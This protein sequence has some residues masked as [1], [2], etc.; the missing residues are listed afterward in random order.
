MRIKQKSFLIA[1]LLFGAVVL[2]S[3]CKKKLEDPK[4]LAVATGPSV[5]I[6]DLRNMYA[7]LNIKFTSNSILHAVVTMDESS[8]NAYKMVYIRDNSGPAVTNGYGAISL[9][10]LNSSNGYLAVGDSIAINLNG[11][12]LD[13]SNGGS[14]QL[15]SIR[16][17]SNIVKIKTGLNPAPL[18]ITLPQLNTVVGTQ[19]VYDGQ[20][21]QLNNVE[22]VQPNVGLPY[23]TGQNP[24]AA[25]VSVNRYITDCTGN[26]MVSY[27]SGYSNFAWTPSSPVVIPNNSGTIVGIGNLYTTMQLTLRSYPDINLYGSYCPVIYDTITQNFTCAALASKTSIMLAG[28]KNSDALGSLKWTGAQYSVPPIY[29]YSPSVSN[30]KS[31]SMRNDIWWVSPPIHDNGGT[32][33]FDFSTAL[34][35]GTM[36]RLLTVLV[37]GTYDGVSDPSLFSWTDISSTAFNTYTHIATT[38]TNGYPIFKYASNGLSTPSSPMKGFVPPTNSGNFYIAFRYQSNQNLSYPDSSG[39]TYLIGNFILKNVP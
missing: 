25:P 34:Q 31:A 26:T 20:L 35:Y 39:S 18:V 7:F 9:H 23:A 21:V 24:P 27:N 19:Y 30:Y 38:N 6:Q 33:Y 12:T 10:F 2:F 32:K 3:S 28:W 1:T 22:F 17:T 14:L 5:T 11:V 16:P 37:S 15:D 13:M 36:K 4:Q 8:G 29:K